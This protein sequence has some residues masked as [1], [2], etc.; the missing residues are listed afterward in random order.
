[1]KRFF[2]IILLV[3]FAVLAT[4]QETQPAGTE[5]DSLDFRLELGGTPWF[6]EWQNQ[7]HGLTFAGS[8]EGWVALSDF[9][10]G[11]SYD[12]LC[13]LFYGGTPLSMIPP[14]NYP[15]RPQEGWMTHMRLDV[16]A[17]YRFIPDFR[18]AAGLGVALNAHSLILRVRND[19]GDIVTDF[20]EYFR[21]GLTAFLNLGIG[22]GLD[23]YNIEIRNE[24]DWLPDFLYYGGVRN[25][26]H[27]PGG[28][29]TLYA[30]PGV[31]LWNR[32]S[33]VMSPDITSG[34]VTI[35]LGAVFEFR[36]AEWKGAT[37]V[38][39]VETIREQI[40]RMEEAAVGDVV[41]F[42][43]I[44]FYPDSAGIKEEST[45]VLEEIARFLAENPEV[46][47]E[48]R[49]YTNALGSPDQEQELSRARAEAVKTF[50]LKKGIAGFRI[51]TVGYGSIFSESGTIQE[52]N[53]RVEI[54]ILSRKK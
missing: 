33:A 52:A 17:A 35:R 2:F 7:M 14:D 50:M 20:Q 39:Y 31:F 19:F 48:L 32:N 47:I 28:Q 25:N 34:W 46:T 18:I 24:F 30:E 41:T 9:S 8:A 4:A 51:I 6:F 10:L 15:F 42:T 37:E 44:V 53:R 43:N 11:L 5:M 13:D 3:F 45:P 38:V 36:A 27:L 54:K 29:F 26:F 21:L 22:F 40:T 16:F 12:F 49:G 1:M 23:W